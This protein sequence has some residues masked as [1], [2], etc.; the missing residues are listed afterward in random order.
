[1]KRLSLLAL[2][3]ALSAPASATDWTG[4][5]VGG[6]AGYADADAE[7]R[8]TLGDAWA[9]ES[10]AL[11][12]EVTGRL[13]NDLQPSG[14]AYGL[15]VGYDHAFA[16]GFLLGGELEY[17][18][19]GLDE[20]RTDGPR[21][22]TAFPS[23][24]YATVNAVEVNNALAL[25]G[26]FGYAN[27]RNAFYGIIGV[28]RVD[29]EAAAGIAS[30]GGYAKAGGTSGSEDALLY[31]VGYAYDFG[32]D[33]TLRAELVRTDAGKVEFDTNYLPG[34]A[35]VLPAYSESFKQ[36]IRYDTLRLGLSYRF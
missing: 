28:A 10:A 17:T 16:S 26:K 14:A 29:V 22:T 19:L 20:S 24:S 21:P 1:M 32:N 36:D 34:S 11:R 30:N 18:H 35:F 31:G 27:G 33:W 5:Y 9:S 7:P 8:V 2:A 13:S 12:D 23:L 25:R 15:H 4:W 3:L 6:H